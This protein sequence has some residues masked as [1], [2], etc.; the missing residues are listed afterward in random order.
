MNL[1]EESDYSH[2]LIFSYSHKKLFQ[3]KLKC[4]FTGLE[5]AYIGTMS[6]IMSLEDVHD[7]V[8][9]FTEY[10]SIN[11]SRFNNFVKISSDGEVTLKYKIDQSNIYPSSGKFMSKN[12][13][14]EIDLRPFECRK[15]KFGHVSA[16]YDYMTLG[17][18]IEIVDSR[19]C[20]ALDG[21]KDEMR[22]NTEESM[23]NA[24][25]WFLRFVTYFNFYANAIS[26]NIEMY[27]AAS[28]LLDNVDDEHAELVRYV[29]DG[30]HHW[31]SNVEAKKINI[32]GL[33][34]CFETKFKFSNDIK[35]T[36]EKIVRNIKG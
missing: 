10:R 32:L 2:I 24:V 28:E 17:M 19:I 3:P 6:N 12:E 31:R 14:L 20:A 33:L 27:D 30:I 18:F 36:I 7:F 35:Q 4:F 29:S 8:S 16:M 22:L 21:V 23:K 1:V 5:L 13:I 15:L 11:L 26:N 34:G 9:C 25:L